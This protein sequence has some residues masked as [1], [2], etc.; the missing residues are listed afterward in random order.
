MIDNFFLQSFSF[1]E[2]CK[3][4]ENLRI[5]ISKDLSFFIINS[6]TK[7]EVLFKLKISNILLDQPEPYEFP[8]AKV[9]ITAQLNYINA[10]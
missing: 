9:D 10:I 7:D 1:D 3:K 5:P 2:F 4:V 6:E 8:D